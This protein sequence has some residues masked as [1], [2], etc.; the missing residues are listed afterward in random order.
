MMT[1]LTRKSVSNTARNFCSTVA[2][3]TLTTIREVSDGE[4]EVDLTVTGSM[5]S[6]GMTAFDWPSAAILFTLTQ[7]SGAHRCTVPENRIFKDALGSGDA[8]IPG[9]TLER[10]AYVWERIQSRKCANRSDNTA[11]LPGL[12]SPLHGGMPVGRES[13]G[14]FRIEGSR[15][16]AIRASSIDGRAASPFWHRIMTSCSGGQQAR[17]ALYL[18]A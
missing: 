15:S 12:A 18:E 7:L 17:A 8:S 4:G 1:P 13:S 6:E 3:R 5:L 2:L 14:G 10:I 11:C 16:A 9:S